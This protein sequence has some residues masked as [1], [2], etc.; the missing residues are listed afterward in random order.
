[1]TKR[2]LAQF[3]R[4]CRHAAQ[5]SVSASGAPQAAVVGVA[6]SDDL[7]VFFDTLA[8]TRK[9]ENLRRDG[10]AALVLWDAQCTVQIDGVADEPQSS[11]LARLKQLYFDSFPDGRERE[12]WPDITYF[13]VRPRWLRYSDFS[14]AEPRI[15]EMDLA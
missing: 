12:R 1:M 14:G 5:A 4:R 8:T 10:R 6:V 13:R 7:E 15:I 11:E 9:A 3:M 2:E